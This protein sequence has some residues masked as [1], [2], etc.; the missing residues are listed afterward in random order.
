MTNKA[1]TKSTMWEFLQSLGKTF[2]LPVALLAFSGIL[3][4]VGSSLSSSA[5]REAIPFLD[6][7]LLQYLFMWMTKIGLVAFIYL[8]VMFAI[9]IPLGLAREEKGVAAFAGFVGYAAF[10]LAINFYLTVA[11]VLGDPAASKAYGVKSIIGIESIDTG[12]LGAVLVGI[13]VAKLHIRFYKFKM[14]DALA[15]FGG[16]RF[17][18]IISAITL[19]VVGVLIPFVWPYFAA[20]INGIGNLIAS[21]GAFGPML[22]GTGERLLLPIG[23]HHI[24]VAL[25][26]FTEAGGT[27]A[28][29]GET[30]S[31]ALNIFYSELACAETNGFT[32]E[33]TAFLS[34][35]KMPAFL[36]GL[37]GAAL[38]MYHCAKP[39]NRSK[40]KALLISGV[41]ACV[42][43]GITE[44]LE[45][46]FL[47][48]APAL[49]FIH[50]ILTGLGFMVMGL[51]D[52]TIGNTDGNIIDF[53]VFGV[54]QGTA[55]KWYLVP[56]VAAAWFAVYYG[57]FKFAILKFN[58]KTPGREVDTAE[59]DS[60]LE[61]A[62]INESGKGAAIL[63]ALGGKDNITSLD[64][65]ITRLRLT[66]DNMDLVDADKLKAYGALGVVKLDAH[67]LQ[68]VIGTQVHLV[69]NE[70]QALM[71]ATAS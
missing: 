51:L 21:A 41:V 2:M 45:F 44:P 9:A 35:G 59:V 62:F 19:G 12:I 55:T 17:V 23:L 57:V 15:F 8:P 20:G 69:K 33:V 36:G 16:A 27:M 13:I 63:K 7:T 14:P 3:L 64:N 67:S 6:N 10:N 26:R 25:V 32:P 29:C 34:Q 22:F 60:E 50:A 11:N 43:G 70:M 58:L 52:V 28:V 37:P 46:L 48:V 42:V 5:I 49:Y 66:V 30:V 24:L 53:L 56:V 61:A 18:P 68:V 40:I 1:A 54:L 65:C 39:E 71:T 4:G 38:A 31:G 47:F